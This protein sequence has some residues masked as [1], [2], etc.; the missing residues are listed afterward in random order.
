VLTGAKA[1]I[2]VTN[3]SAYDSLSPEDLAAS[4]EEPRVGVDC[5]G[6]LDRT[7]FA[8]SGIDLATLGVGEEL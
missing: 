7:L 3:H 2:L 5:W 4:M 8:D 1:F 6:M